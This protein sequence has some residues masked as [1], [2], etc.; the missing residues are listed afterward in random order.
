MMVM[1]Y[2]HMKKKIRKKEKREND[3]KGK[4]KK[5]NPKKT[6]CQFFLQEIVNMYYWGKPQRMEAGFLGAN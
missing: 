3:K 1:S 5:D 6:T 2:L 4:K